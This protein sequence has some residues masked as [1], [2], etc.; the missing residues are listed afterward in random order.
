ME[1]RELALLRR[2]FRGFCSSFYCCDQDEQ[3]NIALKEEHTFRVCANIRQIA[4]AE[5]LDES[6]TTL[7]EA[8][9]LFHDIGRFPQYLRYK[10]F[11]DSSSV[12]HASLGADLLI[13]CM[14]LD[15]LSHDEQDILVHA[16]RFHNAF[17]MP[18]DQCGER[19]L[20][21]KLIRDA[22]KIDIWRVF[23]DYYR[24]P[25]EERASAVSLGFPDTPEF[26]PEVLNS[27]CRGEMV[28]LDSVY[29]LNDFKLLQISWVYDLN[30]TESFRMFQE[31][32]YLGSLEATLPPGPEIREALDAIRHYVS[33]A[34]GD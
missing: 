2:W 6:R 9:G 12:N 17:I 11:R 5:S 8:V 28:N 25:E 16:V 3:R 27:L 14:V 19:D 34:A 24:L 32:N 30:F 31:R 33:T 4:R 15:K 7:A 23:L 20:Y 26:T 29:T 10:T 21:L 18:A 13:Q 22:D 1:R